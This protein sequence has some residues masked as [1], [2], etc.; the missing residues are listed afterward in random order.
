MSGTITSR[1]CVL[2]ITMPDGSKREVKPYE[3]ASEESKLM[4]DVLRHQYMSAIAQR[5]RLAE[6][7]EEIV[8]CC[9]EQNSARDYA[10]RQYEIQTIAT[11][12]L[13]AV[14]WE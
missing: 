9:N 10:S 14:K 8:D 7:L 4:I 13:A 1:D 11:S 12:A 5:D 2:T 3:E 6:A